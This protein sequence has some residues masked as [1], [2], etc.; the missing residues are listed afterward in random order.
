MTQFEIKLNRS[1][2]RPAFNIFNNKLT[3]LLDTGALFPIWTDDEELLVTM[4]NAEFKMKNVTFGGFGGETTGNL[5]VI[6]SIQIGELN[7]VNLHII[8]CNDMGTVPYH[9]ILSA[10]MLEGLIYEINT[11]KNIFKVSVPIG[12]KNNRHLKIYDNNGKL[13]VLCQAAEEPATDTEDR[14]SKK[15]KLTKED[16]QANYVNSLIKK[17]EK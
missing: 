7:F 2:N 16:I 17:S 9:M 8:A 3:A 4:L 14:K 12:E 15:T 10:T 1:I 11:V 6:P 5:Y 13:H